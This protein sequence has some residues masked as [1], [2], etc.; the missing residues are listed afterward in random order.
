MAGCGTGAEPIG[1]ALNRTEGSFLAVDCRTSLAYARTK[2]REHGV[3][4]VDFRH[5]DILK[6][7]M[8]GRKFDLIASSG[9]PPPHGEPVEG[10]RALTDLLNPDGVMRIAL[11]SKPPA[12]AFWRRRRLPGTMGMWARGTA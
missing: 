8:L 10:W 5:G 7:H 9:R 2:A 11:Y 4:N 1:W 12:A 3:T 6:L